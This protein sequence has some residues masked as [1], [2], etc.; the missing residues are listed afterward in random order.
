MCAFGILRLAKCFYHTVIRIKRLGVLILLELSL[1]K[2]ALDGRSLTRYLPEW[3]A[4]AFI[5]TIR[6]RFLKVFS[7]H[8]H[9]SRILIQSRKNYLWTASL[10]FPCL[11]VKVQM[12]RFLCQKNR[13]PYPRA[14][15]PWRDLLP[16]CPFSTSPTS[17]SRC[18][19]NLSSKLTRL[20][21]NGT[22]SV[23][24]P[25]RP[26]LIVGL[27]KAFAWL[28]REECV[29]SDANGLW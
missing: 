4:T 13:L 15:S 14:K 10:L 25:V 21:S 9:S 16:T 22:Q 1:I 29:G 5:S 8:H 23:R 2:G 20:N 6:M 17:R 12:L 19:T 26:L 24:P 18:R 28:C 3:L 27:G 7:H 11:L